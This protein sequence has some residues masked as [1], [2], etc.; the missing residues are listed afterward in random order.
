MD[1][2]LFKASLLDLV[3]LFACFRL[4]C[5]PILVSAHPKNTAS[6]C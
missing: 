4:T 1:L 3:E 2:R 5:V 6:V